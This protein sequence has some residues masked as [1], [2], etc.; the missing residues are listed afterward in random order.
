MQERFD[1]LIKRLLT[2]EIT[3]SE[4]REL[5]SLLQQ[6]QELNEAYKAL[7]AAKPTQT[8]DDRIEAQQ[9]YAA[10]FAKLQVAGAFEEEKIISLPT[11]VPFHKRRSLQWAAIFLLVI[12]GATFFYSSPEP[13]GTLTKPGNIVSTKKGSKSQVVLADGTR[14]WLNADSRL[15]YEGDFTGTT[16]EVSLTG[17]G[18][19]EVS[20][21]KTRPFIIHTSSLDIK[22]LG[23]TFNVR[24][25]PDET[26]AETALIEGKI[27]VTL[28]S[29]SNNKIVLKPSEKLVVANVPA[30]KMKK[31][32]N[33]EADIPMLTISAFRSKEENGVP[34]ETSWM[35]NKLV[36]D[37]EALDKVA[38]MIERWYNVEVII[39]NDSLKRKHFTGYFEGNSLTEVLEAL[40]LSG[41]IKY[42]VTGEKVFIQ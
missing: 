14:V 39:E 40:H 22:V 9:A 32:V 24:S 30:G 16:R 3:P 12:G 38:S 21:D 29:Q 13:G 1:H 8:D 2:N 6:N 31:E 27:E 42:K 37:K 33:P 26:T 18:F 23:T 36:F 4:K 11:V 5:F 7:Y 28:R 17:E 35:Q 25:Y 41:G 10:H 19:F 15:A 20:K 34:A